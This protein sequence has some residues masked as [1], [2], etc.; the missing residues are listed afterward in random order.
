LP[1]YLAPIKWL[2]V[3]DDLTG[4]S[5]VDEDGY[6]YVP[7][8]HN[9]L[10]Y[11]YAA[12]AR[13]ARAGIVCK[14]YGGQFGRGDLLLLVLEE[15]L[16]L[17]PNIPV[18]LY[19]VT[20]DLL[21]SVNVLVAKYPNVKFSEQRHKLSHNELLRIFRSA[22]IYIGLSRSDGIST[23]FLEA[24]T[25]GTYPIQ[26]DTSCAQE[27]VT[28][29]ATASIV[30]LDKEEILRE[31]RASYFNLDKLSL[32]QAKNLIVS[33]EYL[34]YDQIAEVGRTFYS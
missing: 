7:E 14:A 34:D 1:A 9:K 33:D 22:R 29:G 11:F 10:P 6:S 19:S 28:K 18:F 20:E 4:P 25:A 26:S 17:A 24:L 32:A 31:L 2:G 3:T 16:T 30:R 21:E 27:W 5:R 12:N 15:F 8:P 23:S 13:D